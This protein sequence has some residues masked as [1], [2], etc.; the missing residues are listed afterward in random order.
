ME[1]INPNKRKLNSM[2]VLILG[3]FCLICTLVS[4]TERYGNPMLYEL[5]KQV[6]LFTLASVGRSQVEDLGLKPAKIET[7]QDLVD[8]FQE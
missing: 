7:R 6:Q 8:Y 3:L 4:M 1:R 5:L 2:I